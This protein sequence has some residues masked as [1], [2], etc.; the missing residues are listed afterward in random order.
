MP[1]E[2]FIRLQRAKSAEVGLVYSYSIYITYTV[3]LMCIS[4]AA[5]H[6]VACLFPRILRPRACINI[7]PTYHTVVSV[8]I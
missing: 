3:D 4:M 7:G 1:K 8:Y 2:L 5:F 6:I